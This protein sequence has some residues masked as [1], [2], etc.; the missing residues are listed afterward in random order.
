MN[1]NITSGLALGLAH[2]CGSVRDSRPLFV[3]AKSQKGKRPG[4]LTK[5]KV[6]TSSSR[7]LSILHSPQPNADPMESFTG[8]IIRIA[9][10]TVCLSISALIAFFAY[11]VIGHAILALV[12]LPQGVSLLKEFYSYIVLYRS[13]EALAA[14]AQASLKSTAPIE[15][16]LKHLT[17][18]KQ[19]IKHRSC[20]ERSVPTIFNVI[21]SALT[22]PHAVDAGFSILGHLT[23]RLLLQKLQ[24]SVYTHTLKLFPVFLERLA[25]QRDRVRQRATA[26]ISDFY[27]VSDEARKDVEQFVRDTVLVTRNPRAKQAA[28]QWILEV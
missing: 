26:A 5:S 24:N 12:A 13:M 15:D 3:V 4:Q 20:P 28:M 7:D 2:A 10:F 14:E 21:R 9:D 25:D 27:S 16:K 1:F 19:E 11:G 8:S 6:S 17:D 22:I 18:L 23:K